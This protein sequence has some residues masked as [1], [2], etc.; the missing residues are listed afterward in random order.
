MVQVSKRVFHAYTRN[1]PVENPYLRRLH[2]RSSKT[3]SNFERVVALPRGSG[4]DWAPRRRHEGRRRDT[5][6][7]VLAPRA[8]AGVL[9]PGG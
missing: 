7:R 6:A 4:R 1:D 5:E 8:W 3:P 9:A 2:R